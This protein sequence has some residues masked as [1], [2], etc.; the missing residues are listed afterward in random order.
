MAGLH[1]IIDPGVELPKAGEAGCTGTAVCLPA[2][3][4]Y[5]IPLIIQDRSFD[6]AGQIFYN[7]ASNP[8]P[9]PTV[10]PYWIPEFIG[11]AILVNG[12]TWPFL[13]VEPR[14]YRFRFV[15][16]SNARF[17][18]L[19]LTGGKPFIVIATDVGYLDT[20]VSTPNLII[21]PGERYEV[22]VDFTGLVPNAVTPPTIVM[23][24][25]ARTPFPGGA[26]VVKG[27]TD[28]IMQF[29]VKNPLN[30][31]IPNTAIAVGTNL[32][33]SNPIVNIKAATP[34]IK[35]QLT[36]N[37][38]VGPGGPLELVLNNTKYNKVV[39]GFAT[40]ET[41]M[42]QIGATELWEIINITADAHPMHIHFASFQV[43]N[44][45]A[46]QASAWTRVYNN[47]L[48]LTYGPVFDGM[49]PP[50]P[51]TTRNAD[52]AIGGNPAI[53][54]YLQAKKL[55]LPLPYENG[56]KDT[57]ITYPGE[58]T[59]IMVR[60]TPTDIAVGS[61]T[62]GMNQYVGLNPLNLIN[63]VGYVWHCHI[64]DHE[65]NEMMRPYTLQ[66]VSQ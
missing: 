64:V 9:N 32:R 23:K 53:G 27:T 37:E 30:A 34:L 39:T 8:Q 26:K 5:D 2:F 31:G 24:N 58:V 12:K 36:L 49:G 41:E 57:V 52:G 44:R 7:L 28:T 6:T 65:D 54:P 1:P 17:Y 55:T 40:R 3:P 18:D 38:V 61:E 48:A 51:Y 56:W 21:G 46:F 15:N 4:A 10:H 20:A 42:P 13:D 47:A 29:R 66:T 50:N 25:S 60:F 22:I 19:T 62:P 35:R 59:R 33:P 14:Q 16:G 63:G 11:D 43:V 45:Q